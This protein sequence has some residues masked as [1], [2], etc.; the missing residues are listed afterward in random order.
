M[1]VLQY[2]YSYYSC[3][4]DLF[5]LFH[6]QH[7]PRTHAKLWKSAKIAVKHCLQTAVNESYLAM[8]GGSKTGKKRA[9]NQKGSALNAVIW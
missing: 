2:G 4:Y 9:T 5:L 8:N 1:P 7:D 6:Q 3:G